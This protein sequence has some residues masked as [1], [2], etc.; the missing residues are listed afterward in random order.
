MLLRPFVTAIRT[1][2][3]IPLPGKDTERFHLALLFFPLVGGVLGLIHLLIFRL[4][5]LSAEL[6]PLYGVILCMTNYLLS[7]ALHLDGFAD[8]ADAF[9]TV[10]NREKTLQILK[11]CHLGTYGV[12]S[13]V[14]LILWRV[15]LYQ[16]LAEESRLLWIV[17]C[18]AFSRTIQA[19]L[20][21]TLPYARDISGKAFVFCGKPVYAFFLFLE[22]IVIEVLTYLYSDLKSFLPLIVGLLF[23]I[24]V[25][26]L[27]L[28]RVKGI[29]G[30]G[31]GASSELFELGFLTATMF[32]L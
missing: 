29:T 28:F 19:I 20:L 7:G 18:L 31:V 5:S 2:T 22:M 9:G 8:T 10:R 4:L 23:I 25:V 12:A 11:D 16:T 3:I 30:D 26:S 15:V 32:L 24:P 21:C 6:T 14:F 27:Y 13:V 17:P 1:L